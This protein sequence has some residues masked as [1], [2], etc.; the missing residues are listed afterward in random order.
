MGFSS[1]LS[2]KIKCL[3]NSQT[4]ITYINLRR[5]SPKESETYQFQR[6]KMQ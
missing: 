6:L 2:S 1:C 5:L 4:F 3:G